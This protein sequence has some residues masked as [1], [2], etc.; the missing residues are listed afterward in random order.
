METQGV[1]QFTKSGELWERVIRIIPSGTQTL[2]KGPNNFVQ[3][4]FP[5]FLKSGRV[6]KVLDEVKETAHKNGA[7]LIFYEV[8]TGFR[9]APGGAQ[10][11]FNVT[12]DLAYF[13][14]A[15]AKGVS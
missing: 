15:V 4:A 2:S 3:G 10:E 9:F 1:S 13:D 11:Y 5:I 6:S 12:P 7:L 8:K 14:K